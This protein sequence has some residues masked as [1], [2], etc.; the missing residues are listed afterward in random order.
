MK[1]YVKGEK[2]SNICPEGSQ[3]FDNAEDCEQAT[4]SLGDRWGRTV[5]HPSYPK[6][7]LANMPRM[8]NSYAVVYFNDHP[9]GSNGA[10]IP[11]HWAPI[12]F[13]AGKLFFKRRQCTLLSFFFLA[14]FFCQILFITFRR[15]TTPGIFTV[16]KSNRESR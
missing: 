11:P 10:E 8:R 1:M 15:L 6:G 13:R 14:I 7:C 9:T 5:T 16:R 3:P 4:K 12:C 2:G